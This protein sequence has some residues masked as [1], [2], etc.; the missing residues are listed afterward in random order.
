MK[1]FMILF[2]L[3]TS[4]IAWAADEAPQPAESP[5]DV[6]PECMDLRTNTATGNC[7]VQDNG[8]PRHLRPPSK[9]IMPIAP[10]PTIPRPPSAPAAMR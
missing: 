6:H 4:Q 3:L 9:P 7:I 1:R 2:M 10:G 5:F 8:Q